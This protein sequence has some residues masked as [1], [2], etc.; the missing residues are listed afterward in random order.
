M[1]QQILKQP[2]PPHLKEQPIRTLYFGGGTPSLLSQQHIQA[3]W[4]ALQA[5]FQ[6]TE[7]EEWTF[8]V[9]PENASLDYLCSLKKLGV[10]RLS[11]GIQSFQPNILRHMHRSH[12]A[13]QAVEAVNNIHKAG[14]SSF[15]VDLIYAYPE[16]RTEQL[17]QDIEHFIQLETPHISAYA[18]TLEEKTRLWKLHEEG[19]LRLSS[20][21]L[22]EEHAKIVSD[23]LK[24]AGYL[25]YEVSNFALAGHESKH[26]SAYWTHQNYHAFGPGAHGFYWSSDLDA[27]QRWQIPAQLEEYIQ[28][29]GL[30]EPI[31]LD[32]LD[33]ADLA[34]E[35]IM[36]GLRTKKGISLSELQ[37][38]YR[39][40]LRDKQIALISQFIDQNYVDKTAFEQGILQ[41]THQGW[42]L[43]D[44]LVYKILTA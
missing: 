16:Q 42:L 20:D 7:L 13:D 28:A 23:S 1:I 39:F 27:A 36:L 2:L 18:L 22:Q 5:R 25:H 3:I 43:T 24:K 38:K 40:T 4:Q 9:N 6:L 21:T 14:F 34:E 19:Q 12:T 37:K 8:E 11:M 31:T 32:Q 44:H 10:N 41:V 17:K 33:L 15:S 30:L 35:R 26:N 29:N